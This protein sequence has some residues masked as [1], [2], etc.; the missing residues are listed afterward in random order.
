M[1]SMHQQLKAKR[2]EEERLRTE[3]QRSVMQKYFSNSSL[4]NLES[5]SDWLG[6]NKKSMRDLR[7]D[8]NRYLSSFALAGP[9]RD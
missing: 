6:Q 1:V 7:R 5:E 8:L 2:A 9:L 4:W 3:R